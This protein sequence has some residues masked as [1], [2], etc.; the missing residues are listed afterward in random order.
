[1]KPFASYSRRFKLNFK[2]RKTVFLKNLHWGFPLKPSDI[3][4]G[5][6]RESLESQNRKQSL[7]MKARAKHPNDRKS[8][9]SFGS[10]LSFLTIRAG[11]WA[12]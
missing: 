1:M 2:A 7:L 10:S 3:I 8:I 12:I 4:S 6:T 11:A 5:V 9:S